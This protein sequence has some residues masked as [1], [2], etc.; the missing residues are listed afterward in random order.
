MR[1]TRRQLI[2]TLGALAAGPIH[3]AVYPAGVSAGD[4]GRLTRA[5]AF[6]CGL[7]DAALKK[8]VPAQ[9]GLNFVG[10]ANCLSGRQEEQLA[11][12]PERPDEVYCR[13][14]NHRYPSR[15]YPMEQAVT[16][17]NPRG[18]EQRYPYWANASGYRY[19]FEA[20]RDDL[21]RA[22]LAGAARSLAMLHA[23]GGDRQHAARA[24]LLLDRFAEVF[25]GWCYHNDLPFRQKTIYDG[26]VPPA[27]F[28]PNF[29]TA[30]WTWWAYMD[31]PR[32]L[33]QAY[34]WI[35][36]SEVLDPAARHR[37]EH[38]FFRSAAD[39]VLANPEEFSNMSP[40][41][42]Y[43][44]VMLG[45]VIGE[46][47]YVNEPKQRLAQ[48][49]TTR[50]F[51]DGAWMEGTPSYHAQSINGLK[52]VLEA[53]GEPE[54]A[55]P[56]LQRSN[57]ALLKMRL[58]DGRFVPVHDTWWFDKRAPL[59]RTEPYLLPALGHACLGARKS[60]LHL[61]WSGGYGHQ[62]YDN[63]N[64]ILFA[65]CREM[66]SDIG[67]THTRYRAWGDATA[68]H[69]T[70]V[71]DG[72]SQASGSVS[73]PTDGALRWFDCRY[74]RVQSVSA[75]GGRG[76]SGKTAV[77]RRTLFTIDAGEDRWYVVDVFEVEG[78][79]IHDYFLHGDADAQSTVRTGLKM[80]A[81]AT[82][83][84]D[85]IEWKPP[86]NENDYR[87]FRAPW[88]AYGF[89]HNLRAA[90]APAGKALAVDFPGL[91]VTLFPEAGSR[92]I[93]GENPSIRH[94]D[95]DDAKLD[96]FER[97]FL[98]LRHD[99][100]GRRST[101]TAVLEPYNS[102]P[103]VTSVERMENGLRVRMGGR[104][105][106][107]SW[108]ASPSVSIDG[109]QVWALAAPKSLSLAAVE[110][111]ALVLASTPDSPPT[112]GEV[113]RL[114]TADGWVYPFTVVSALG[115]RVQVAEGPGMSYDA[116]TQHLRLTAFPQRE[117]MGL[118]RVR[119]P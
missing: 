28:L 4:V 65:Q 51:Y 47:S 6:V 39:Q 45:R 31:I 46:P 76:Y 95:E 106:V 88:Y 32:E 85:G 77:Y 81:L 70:V 38:D 73:A 19:F 84:P 27:T 83:L 5:T 116:A 24:A 90:N 18:E 62:H 93:L 66:L 8:L 105:D 119:W 25:P 41:A 103:S 23:A 100:K 109:R 16:V 102:A 48:F 20:R 40:T 2:G 52:A 35:S 57:A 101:F 87:P 44:L 37:I 11:W 26:N 63:L 64:V 1:P 79:R 78:G 3:G 12:T 112:P 61:T 117:H 50:F 92:L 75:D 108:G 42:W 33:V 107:I 91:R 58:P 96:Q 89:L 94:A 22:Y 99:A 29:R 36:S 59:E 98:L 43:S 53:L 115:A 110:A 49:T 17:R 71:I 21:V 104:T 97:P 68:S 55:F 118:V 13:Y 7:D 72:E 80:E 9:S 67:Y 82:L 111:D 10:C 15:K 56:A 86:Q 54:S 74:P 114:V 69:N 30:R 60:Q 113:V 14:C 34:D